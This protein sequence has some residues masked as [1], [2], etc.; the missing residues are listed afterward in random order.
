MLTAFQT[1]I[2]AIIFVAFIVLLS[3][4][5]FALGLIAFWIVVAALISVMTLLALTITVAVA[6]NIRDVAVFIQRRMRDSYAI[7]FARMRKARG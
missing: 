3:G 2:A 1:L 4:I 6:I 7:S 5:G